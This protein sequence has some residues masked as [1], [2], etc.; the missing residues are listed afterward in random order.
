MELIFY[1]DKIENQ[2][3]VFRLFEWSTYKMSIVIF[4]LWVTRFTWLR[5]NNEIQF[6]CTKFFHKEPA[7]RKRLMLVDH[8]DDEYGITRERER[9]RETE[10]GRSCNRR[11]IEW[12]YGRRPDIR[13]SF[14]FES[15]LSS[16][17]LVVR[18]F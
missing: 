5:E 3:T 12:M 7:W 15:F 14:K 17:F 8:M 2:T 13:A 1:W 11:Q 10:R 18:E 6:F 16:T 4:S 9:E